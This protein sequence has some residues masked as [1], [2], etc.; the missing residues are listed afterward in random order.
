MKKAVAIGVVTL[1]LAGGMALS[2]GAGYLTMCG[3][4]K[5]TRAAIK[6]LP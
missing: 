2:Y 5:L 3:Y 6:R 4:I 1:W